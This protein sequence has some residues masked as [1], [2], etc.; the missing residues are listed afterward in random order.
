[1]AAMDVMRQYEKEPEK[2]RREAVIVRFFTLVQY[3]ETSELALTN[4][5]AGMCC[6]PIE[7]PPYHAIMNNRYFQSRWAPNIITTVIFGVS[8]VG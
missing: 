2:K 5:T 6:T 3:S 4:T 7:Q 8:L 1:M